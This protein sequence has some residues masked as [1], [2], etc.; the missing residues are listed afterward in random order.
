M[1]TWNV[2][3]GV[4]GLIEGE[5]RE[6]AIRS[7]HQQLTAAGFDVYEGQPPDAFLSEAS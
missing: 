6:E 3:L 5:S 4:V 1:S 7:F 2:L